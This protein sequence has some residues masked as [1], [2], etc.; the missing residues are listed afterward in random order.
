MRCHS[1]LSR[2]PSPRLHDLTQTPQN[3]VFYEAALRNFTARLLT[4]G[5]KLAFVSTTPFMPAYYRG[6]TIVE[7]L[8]AIAAA[9]MKEHS[10]P[11]IDTY[12]AVTAVCGSNYSSCDLCDN[13]PWPA[14]APAGAHCG[15]H[16]T[17]LGYKTISDTLAPAIKALLP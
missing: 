5:A 6:D 7:D 15:Y 11:Y 1:P 16:Y 9:I 13:E 3:K 2:P 8:N 14:P 12:H 4:T 17:P 10:I